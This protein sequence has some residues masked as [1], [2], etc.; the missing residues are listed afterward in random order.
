MKTD[1]DKVDAVVK[2][3]APKTLKQV[4]RFVGMCGWYRRFIA[5]Y[6]AISSSISNLL[7]KSKNFLGRKKQKKLSKC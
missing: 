2:Y 3:E 1:P 5:N 6:S 7:Q 4:R